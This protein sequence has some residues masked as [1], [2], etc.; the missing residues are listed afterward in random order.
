MKTVL[1]R[2][3]EFPSLKNAQKVTA[4]ASRH[5]MAVCFLT[6]DQHATFN[7]ARLYI[8]RTLARVEP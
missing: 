7:S 3:A 4:Y 1:T 6:A 8:E 2:F 5:P